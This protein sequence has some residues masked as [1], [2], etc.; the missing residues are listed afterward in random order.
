MDEI[1]CNS[2]LP[3]CPNNTTDI[4]KSQQTCCRNWK[5]VLFYREILFRSRIALPLHMIHL[6]APERWCWFVRTVSAGAFCLQGADR[7]PQ[8]LCCDASA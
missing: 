4:P 3:D 6:Y 2:Y 1:P 7:K 5:T 8:W